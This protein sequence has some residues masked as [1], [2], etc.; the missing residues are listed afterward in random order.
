[1]LLALSMTVTLFLAALLH[2]DAGGEIMFMFIGCLL[3]L[4]L[5]LLLFIHDINQSLAALKVEL[6]MCSSEMRPVSRPPAFGKA[7]GLR[8]AS[9]R[10]GILLE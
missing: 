7:L 10:S 9:L 8:E 1:M 4:F 3:T 5:A 2:W 6:K